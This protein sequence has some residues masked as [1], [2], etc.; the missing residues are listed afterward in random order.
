MLREVFVQNTGTAFEDGGTTDFTQVP[1]LTVQVVNVGRDVT[2]GAAY[3]ETIDTSADVGNSLDVSDYTKIK[4]L[5]YDASEKLVLQSGPLDVST[6]E[7]SD[8]SYTAVQQQVTFVEIPAPSSDDFWTIK[9]TDEESG[10]QPYPRRSY[11]IEVESADSAPD[12][13]NKFITSINSREDSINDYLGSSVYAGDDQVATV[14]IDTFNGGDDFTLTIDGSS[15]TETADTDQA[16]TFANF[17]SSYQTTIFDT[18]GVR[19]SVDSNDDLQLE[20][21]NGQLTLT[22][23]GDLD[24]ATTGTLAVTLTDASTKTELRLEAKEVG[25]IFDVATQEFDPVNIN[26]A[27]TPTTGV[28]TY[29]QVS[30]HERKTR[31]N[32]GRYVQS[33]NILGSLEEPKTYA[34][35]DGNYD[36]LNVTAKGDYDRSMLKDNDRNQYVIALESAVVANATDTDSNSVEDYIDWFSPKIIASG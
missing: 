22:D 24:V 30:E 4:L 5:F 11:E 14:T 17:V 25:D 26:T 8:L 6:L 3:G 7:V 12:A 9:I 21:V 1:D 31:G 27:T 32:L 33:T 29:E 19:V 20:M 28:G 2:N 15:Y 23:A 10:A 13:I 16:T 35:T 34:K 36:L 18:H